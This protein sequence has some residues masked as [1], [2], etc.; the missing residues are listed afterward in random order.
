MLLFFSLGFLLLFGLLYFI[1]GQLPMI[2]GYAAKSMAMHVFLGNRIPEDVKKTDNKVHLVRFAKTEVN[3]EEKWVEA[4]FLGFFKRKAI[5]RNGLGTILIPPKEQDAKTIALPKRET[6]PQAKS[7]PY[8]HLAPAVG[9]VTVND[10]L[11]QAALDQAFS[12]SKEQKTR[13]VV[14]LHKGHLVGERYVS[15]FGPDTPVLGWSMTKSVLATCFGILERQ[16]KID[17]DNPAPV[18]EWQNDERKNITLNHL[19]RMQSGLAWQEEYRMHSDTTR[20]LFH[21]KDVTYS[22]RSKTLVAPPGTKWN[23]ASGTTNVLTWIL[24]QQFDT[25]QEYLDFPYTQLIDKIGMHSMTLETDTAGNY[26]SSSYSFASPR[27]WAKVG[28]LY[29]DK[30]KWNGEQLFNPEWAE[31]VSRLTPNSE[32]KYGA[33]FWVNAKGRYPEVPLDLYSMNGYLGQYVFIIPSKELVVVR[34]GLAED[35]QFDVNTF[36]K[37]V[38]ASVIN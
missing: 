31:Y 26:V 25:Y 5:Y 38:V 13:T 7:Y 24:R 36:L 8:G 32:G 1:I 14:V 35:P 3:L 9:E 16:G 18:P 21:E 27:D 19:L 23:Y 12:N 6:T 33:H 10:E 20:M 22:Q 28:Q 34:T 17:L 30:G 2:N 11:L 4:K 15:G 37:K 29:L